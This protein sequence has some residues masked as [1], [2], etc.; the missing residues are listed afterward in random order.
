MRDAREA[1]QSVGDALVRDAERAGGGHGAQRVEDVEAARQ[2][3]RELE[4]TEAEARRGPAR[5][6]R[7]GAQPRAG[8]VDG[9]GHRVRELRGQAAA[10]R[11]VDVDDAHARRGVGEERALGLEVLLHVAVEVEVV[12]REVREHR[13]VPV[14]RRGAPQGE[15]VRGDLHDHGAVAAVEHLRERPLQVNRL[16]GRAHG[17]A[18][19]PRDDRADGPEQ[20]GGQ[21]T[22]LEQ[23]AD[24][25]GGR[26][27][28]VRAG[29][30][31]GPQRGGRVAVEPRGGRRHRRA[32]VADDDLGHPEAERALHDERGGAAGDG[33]GREVV[34]VAREPRHA[35]EDRSRAHRAVVVGQ[36]GDLDRGSAGVGEDV[37]E[38][39]RQRRLAATPAIR[40]AGSSDT[41]ARTTRSCR[42]RAPRPARRRSP[43]SARRRRRRSA[44]AG[45]APARSR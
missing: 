36:G 2:R 14:D 6:E 43:P 30:P 8:V 11:V 17:I 26:G 42:T 41:A 3:R 27:L 24:E 25:E 12:L 33:V 7:G 32:D 34:T 40:T 28:A 16:R 20:P 22:G 19:L 29:D 13:D 4:V 44:A 31:D 5:L 38:R 21:A 39:H 9:D 37:P 23:R 45:A 1:L 15:R 35:E 10:V 18:P